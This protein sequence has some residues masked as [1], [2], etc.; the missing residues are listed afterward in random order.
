MRK[1][2]APPGLPIVSQLSVGL[3]GSCAV[4][5]KNIT[6][7]DSGM[8]MAPVILAD[9]HALSLDGWEQPHHR[10]RCHTS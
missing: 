6:G 2:Q 4:G 7:A 5:A 10:Q 3:I 9:K 8:L 1:P